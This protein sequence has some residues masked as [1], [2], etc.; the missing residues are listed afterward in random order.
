MHKRE[1]SIIIGSKSDLSTIKETTNILDEFKMS[2]DLKILSAHRTPDELSGYVKQLLKTDVKVVIA[3]AGG[4]AALSGVVASH[5]D[6]PVIGIPIETKNLKGL[7][8][9]LSTVQM[10]PGIPVA[11]V[12][13]GAQGAKNAAL[14]AI[15]IL[16]LNNPG[17]KKALMRYKEKTRKNIIS[18]NRKKSWKRE[19]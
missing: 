6:L 10:P 13:I 5:T 3:A 8:S 9:L 17:L 11:T 7:D 2:Y 1:I 19:F 12:A 18:L 15:R 16:A 14:L 4:A